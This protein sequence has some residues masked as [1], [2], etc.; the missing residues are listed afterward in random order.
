[1]RLHLDLVS[2]LNK[3]IASYLKNEHY[4]TKINKFSNDRINV[5]VFYI[6]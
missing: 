6:I 5:C 2:K 3:L 1:M 4:I